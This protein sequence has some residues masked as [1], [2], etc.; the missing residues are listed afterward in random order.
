MTSKT[1]SFNKH[2]EKK[3]FIYKFSQIVQAQELK[4]NQIDFLNI[5]A[6]AH[7]FEV[8]EGIDISSY[9]VKLI[10]IEMFDSQ[11]QINE[12]KFKD[13]LIKYNYHLIKI[14]GP[15]GFFEFRS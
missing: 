14:I 6:E 3:I 10:C 12:E 4:I 8:L 13:Y 15:N 2:S 9:K 5:D 1:I 11:N 7:D